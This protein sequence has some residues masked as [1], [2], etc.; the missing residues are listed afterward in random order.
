MQLSY[1]KTNL[2]KLS[3][4]D[5]ETTDYPPAHYHVL[6]TVHL[7]WLHTQLFALKTGCQTDGS[8]FFIFNWQVMTTVLLFLLLLIGP[9]INPIRQGIQWSLVFWIPLRGFRVPAVLCTWFQIFVSGTWIPDFNLPWDFGFQIPGFRD[10]SPPPPPRPP[11][12][13][14]NFVDSL[15]WEDLMFK[16]VLKCLRADRTKHVIGPAHIRRVASRCSY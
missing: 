6:D 15:T 13:E 5:E 11:T 2:F 10:S 7:L 4:I 12:K 1:V 14:N 9:S 3:D 16:E 8:V